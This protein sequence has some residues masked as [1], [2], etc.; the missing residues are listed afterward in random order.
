M[1]YPMRSVPDSSAKTDSRLPDSGI[2][3]SISLSVKC[4]TDPNASSTI[5]GATKLSS[6]NDH[7]SRR[8]LD[9]AWVCYNQEE[10]RAYLVLTCS[11]FAHNYIRETQTKCPDSKRTKGSSL[12]FPIVHHYAQLQLFV[13]EKMPPIKIS[14]RFPTL[15]HF[16]T[17]TSCWAGPGPDMIEPEIELARV[18][19]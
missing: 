10:S 17:L 12:I 16:P 14:F 18:H 11:P 4:H 6:G 13:G 8:H 7:P 9:N 19:V 1:R 5:V 15:M 2:R 3:V